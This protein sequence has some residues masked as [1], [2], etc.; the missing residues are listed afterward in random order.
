M[1]AWLFKPFKWLFS[2]G[3]VS[4]EGSVKEVETYGNQKET[5]KYAGFKFTKRF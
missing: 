1:F 5:E 2:N 3:E 4:G